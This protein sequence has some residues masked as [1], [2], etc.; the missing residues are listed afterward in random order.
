MSFKGCPACKAT[1][2]LVVVGTICVSA[3]DHDPFCW[4]QSGSYCEM[5]WN[6]VHGHHED[7][8][9]RSPAYVIGSTSSS[10]NVH[11][12]AVDLS[13]SSPEIGAPELDHL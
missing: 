13:T 6:V 10:G 2:A 11:L 3:A 12:K 4:K 9:P 7:Y 1:A 5:V 8:P